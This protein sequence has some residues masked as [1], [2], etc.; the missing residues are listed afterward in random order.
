MGG[1]N[2]L[3]PLVRSSPLLSMLLKC[4][5][6]G[7]LGLSHAEESVPTDTKASA[8]YPDE[9]LLRDAVSKAP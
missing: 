5:P 7:E 4:L 3:P 6:L 9:H 2:H 8:V 1:L